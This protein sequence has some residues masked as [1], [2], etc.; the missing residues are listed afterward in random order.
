MM[1]IDAHVHYTPPEL[2]AALPGMAESE[3]YWGLIFGA[4]D[5]AAGNQGWV[6]A[7][8][9]I[10]DMDQAGIDRVVIVGNYWVKHETSV[11]RNSEVLDLLKRWPDRFLGFATLQPK[12]GPR[13]LDELARCLDG[14]M[15]GVGELGPYGQ[16]YDLEDPDFLR[17]AEACI[18]RGIPI[19]LHVSEEVGHFYPGKSNTPLA[20]YYRLACRYPELKL[21][22]AHWGGGIFFYEMM[23]E[24][25]AALRNVWYDTAASPLLY[26]TPAIF[27]TALQI[28]D[29]RKILYASDYPLR[30]CRRKQTEGDFRPFIAEIEEQALAP[31]ILDDIMGNNAARLF[32]LSGVAEVKP[33]AREAPPVPFASASPAP[34][35]AI[36]GN[37][38]VRAV[39]SACPE[40]RAV[41]EQF[42]IRWQDA[43]LPFWEPI[44]QAAAARGCGSSRRRQLLE[45]LNEAV[46]SPITGGR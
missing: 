44:A 29:H 2:A 35:A 28:L 17:L 16:N 13:A 18:A 9:M 11:A 24:V 34:G 15:C 1:R 23:P 19:N 46:K 3:S 33:A 8:R 14:G 36:T 40:T 25:R 20:S 10:D 12:A 41:F 38:A 21:I 42:G 4:D 39:A 30:I 6:S 27:R 7:E 32:G 31:T 22:L 26:P 45:A 37:M 5:P 43:P